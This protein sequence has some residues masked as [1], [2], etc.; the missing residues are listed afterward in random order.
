[1]S[2]AGNKVGVFTVALE[3]KSFHEDILHALET[4]ADFSRDTSRGKSPFT[5]IFRRLK[6]VSYRR[7]YL[8]A[9]SLFYSVVKDLEGVKACF[10]ILV[11]I[12]HLGRHGKININ[13]VPAEGT[14]FPPAA[15]YT[16]LKDWRLR[17]IRLGKFSMAGI[18]K[19]SLSKRSAEIQRAHS[20]FILEKDGG[21]LFGKSREHYRYVD[22]DCGI[23]EGCY[24]YKGKKFLDG[25]KFLSSFSFFDK[26]VEALETEIFAGIMD[27]V[28][29]VKETLIHT[30]LKAIARKRGITG[31][32]TKLFIREN[33][34]RIDA[35]CDELEHDLKITLAKLIYQLINVYEITRW[36]NPVL[37]NKGY[38]LKKFREVYPDLFSQSKVDMERHMISMGPPVNV[39]LYELVIKTRQRFLALLPMNAGSCYDEARSVLDEYSAIKNVPRKMVRVGRFIIAT[40][41]LN[42]LYSPEISPK[43]LKK[44]LVKELFDEYKI[45]LKERLEEEK[46]NFWGP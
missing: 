33:K 4:R 39:I 37:G 9:I 11:S 35:V 40:N 24:S 16:V 20:L 44:S 36:K 45:E 25:A 26:D 15:F 14:S 22:F 8:H 29:K 21:I 18:R 42:D 12:P 34:G 7:L 32:R 41:R 5:A 2:P 43:A 46:D 23:S 17:E 13:F 38:F 10:P 19:L 6:Q 28:G 31:K 3:K 27:K 1:M 30:E